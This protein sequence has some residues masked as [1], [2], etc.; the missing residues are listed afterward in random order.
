MRTSERWDIFCRVVDN[1]GDAA[2]CWRLARE[3]AHEQG[4]RVRLWID[5]LESLIRLE[6]QAV[7]LEQ[8]M[9]LGVEVN[10]WGIHLPAEVVPADFVI[11]AF[12]CGLPEQYVQGMAGCARSPIWVVL[13]YLTAESWVADYH[14]LPS[15]HPRL[16]LARY[17]F[18][19]GFVEGTGGLLREQNLFARRDAFSA[20]QR[21]AF[22]RSL[23]HAPP[24][25]G[26]M[27]V[28]LF[29][30]DGAPLSELLRCWENG[31]VNVLAVIPY[32]ALTAVALKH[33][34]QGSIPGGGILRRGALEVRFIPFL[35]QT[36]YD[37]L[38]WSCDYNFVR[39]EDSFVR[40]QWAGQPFVWHAY[41][42]P[43]D[44]HSHKLDAFLELYGAALPAA[45]RT[46]VSDIMHFWNQR[47]RSAVS[48]RRA[49][50]AFVAQR[51]DVQRHTRL[52][53]EH[54]AGIGSLAANLA[55]F[56]RDK[57]K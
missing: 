26:V 5:D 29:A 13:E 24:L 10:R 16:P 31:P 6:P 50:D 12:G 25:P 46:T 4:A 17:F 34:G 45:A 3:L 48:P 20:H 37:E 55:S 56:C 2:V 9:L 30:Y 15:P 38:L 52:W 28:S 32:N 7:L 8:Q 35:A 44:A 14:A 39:G 33:F 23:G 21:D 42:Q 18:F 19:P 54:V 57:L 40:A 53:A 51:D 43:E 49:W 22:W 41:R 11:D 1:F 27:A 47:E 36:Q